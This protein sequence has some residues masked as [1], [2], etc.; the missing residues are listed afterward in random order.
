MIYKFLKFILYSY[1]LT[2]IM[3]KGPVLH[4]A[5][6]WLTEVIANNPTRLAKVSFGGVTLCPI[7]VSQN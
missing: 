2:L 1:T 4:L 3:L 6:S 5:T 7:C